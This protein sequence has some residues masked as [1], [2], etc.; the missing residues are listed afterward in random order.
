MVLNDIPYT[1][2]GQSGSDE[3]VDN[4]LGR[5]TSG[6]GSDDDPQP[7]VGQDVGLGPERVVALLEALKVGVL[8]EARLRVSP[9]LVGLGLLVASDVAEE[10]VV[11]NAAENLNGRQQV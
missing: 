9:V 7:L 1:F 6:S 2:L 3:L 11:G 10:E 5:R 4:L 8:L